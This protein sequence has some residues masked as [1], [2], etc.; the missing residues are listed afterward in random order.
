MN[1]EKFAALLALDWGEDQHAF[2]LQ[3]SGGSKQTGEIAAAPEA[4]HRWLDGLGERFAGQ[5]VAVVVEAGRNSVVHA[6]FEHPWLTVFPI[7]P[8]A[9]KRFR[10]AL[11]PSG[12]KDDIPD[13]EILLTLF[14]HH[15][16]RLR[17]LQPDTP[18]TRRLELLVSA[19]REAVNLR[20]QLGNQLRSV[21]KVHFPQALNLFGDEI[22]TPLPLDFL[23]R[24][25]TL[26]GARKARPGILRAF[27]RA[28]CSRPTVTEERLAVLHTARPLTTDAV[29][30]E[31]GALQVA[32]LVPQL[33]AIQQAVVRFEESIA[34]A[35]AA[36]PDAVLFARLPGAGPTLAPR[37][38]VAFGSDRSRYPEPA[39]LQKYA[40]IAPVREK[41]GRQVWTHWRWHCPK[42]L[43]QSFV[44]WV[45]QTIP[46]SAWARAFYRHQ[47]TLNKGHHAVLRALAFKW[48]R[49]LW[50]CWQTRT[51]Y[52]ES[53]HLQNLLRRRSPHATPCL[54]T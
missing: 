41:S 8:A 30:I 6:L 18:G 5:P 1:I 29:V 48:I 15:H 52:D 17:P 40:G 49:I 53:I 21:L 37:L 46:K 14:E 3:A 34:E 20:T 54:P 11:V 28:H 31:V 47:R 26:D 13:A 45:G 23:T 32:A 7:H 10:K 9:S 25:P 19:R 16:D 27:Y 24:W 51:P 2:A 33:R 42:F 22:Y 50:K 39:S 43:R 38:L 36:H 4:F 35:F 12:A 44:E